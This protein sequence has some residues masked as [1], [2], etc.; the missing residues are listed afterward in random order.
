MNVIFIQ[1]TQTGAHLPFTLPLEK[2]NMNV[3]IPFVSKD[4][5]ILLKLWGQQST[6]G[7]WYE[8]NL[9]LQMME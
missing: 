4:K 6:V 2:C 9:R 5:F 8:F 1:P 3:T 7:L